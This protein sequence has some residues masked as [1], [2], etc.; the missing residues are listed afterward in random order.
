MSVSEYAGKRL[1]ATIDENYR[2]LGK[3]TYKSLDI[4][5]KNPGITYENYRRRDGSREYLAKEIKRG[6]VVAR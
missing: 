4:I 2:T 1:Y 6:N 3:R 5:L